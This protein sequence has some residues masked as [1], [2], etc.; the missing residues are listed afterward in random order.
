[1]LDIAHPEGDAFELHP[2]PYNLS[3]LM[4]KL[5]AEYM[6]FLDGKSFDMK[7]DIPDDDVVT[8]IVARLVERALR[9]L[10]DSA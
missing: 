3:E 1:M 10:P 4:R 2:A 7:A 6:L 5:A 8:V 9:N